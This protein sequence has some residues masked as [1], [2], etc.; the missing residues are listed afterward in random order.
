[1]V[2]LGK[3][4]EGAVEKK[5]SRLIKPGPVSEATMAPWGLGSA[6]RPP[7]VEVMAEVGAALGTVL[8]AETSADGFRR[9]VSRQR[10]GTMIAGGSAWGRHWEGAAPSAPCRGGWGCSGGGRCMC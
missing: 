4:V 1:M 10:A 3:E 7:N 8:G 9:L 5:V 2:G 6:G